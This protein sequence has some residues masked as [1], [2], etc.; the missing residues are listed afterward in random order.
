MRN[1]SLYIGFNLKDTLLDVIDNGVDISISR[2]TGINDTGSQVP[3]PSQG[4]FVPYC[5]GVVLDIRGYRDNN[6][7]S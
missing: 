7:L 3:E 6:Q 1:V 5:L 2:I 4:M